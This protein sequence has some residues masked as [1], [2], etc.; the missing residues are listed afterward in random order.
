VPHGVVANTVQLQLAHDT[1]NL[2][3]HGFLRWSRPISADS[4]HESLAMCSLEQFRSEFH[5]D[6]DPLD[7]SA[8]P[9]K[10][11]PACANVRAAE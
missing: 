8:F 4:E 3:A 1:R 2:N 11:N 10:F 7:A 6:V 5:R 9:T